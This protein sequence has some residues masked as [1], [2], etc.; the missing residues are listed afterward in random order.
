MR[1]LVL[2]FVV[3]ITNVACSTT[4]KVSYRSSGEGPFNDVYIVDHGLH[5]G[6]IINQD[7]IPHALL[8]EKD[9]FSN[10]RYLEF[11]WGDKA[12]YIAEKPTL[13][14][15]LSALFSPTVSV[16]HILEIPLLVKE[17]YPENDIIKLQLS[18][19]KFK[20]LLRYI[21]DSIKRDE[22]GNSSP[23][24][25]MLH[26]SNHFYLAKGKYHAFNTCN[27]WIAKAIHAAGVPITSNRTQTSADVMS[28]IRNVK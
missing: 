8:P 20:N 27:T 19:T 12:F 11:G 18:K 22:Y 3:I 23:V 24:A 5:S 13:A 7:E 14:L 2:V 10:A 6:I 26:T 21:T 25:H 4:T 1:S 15:A 17:Y 16:L 28:Q 9:E